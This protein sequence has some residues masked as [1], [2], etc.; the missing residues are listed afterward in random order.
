MVVRVRFAFVG[1]RSSVSATVAAAAAVCRSPSSVV[2]NL[3]MTASPSSRPVFR[4]P[5]PP[6]SLFRRR[7]YDANPRRRMLRIAYSPPPPPSRMPPSRPNPTGHWPLFRGHAKRGA[8]TVD[9]GNIAFS[10]R[11]TQGCFR[12]DTTHGSFSVQRTLCLL[13]GIRPDQFF[14]G[15]E[16]GPGLQRD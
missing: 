7:H 8:S 2:R 9:G 11:T 13:S 12:F 5:P 1:S 3:L 6:S 15:G 4:S 16:G 14:F 10:S